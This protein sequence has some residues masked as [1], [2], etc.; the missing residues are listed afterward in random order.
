MP[1]DAWK[2]SAE[3]AEVLR[4]YERVALFPEQRADGRVRLIELRNAV[5]RFKTRWG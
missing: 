4:A 3:W 1:D 2:R 5:A